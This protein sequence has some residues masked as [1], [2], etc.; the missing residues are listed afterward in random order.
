MRRLALI[1]LNLICLQSSLA[2][3]FVIK[4]DSPELPKI[5]AFEF[6]I[7][8]DP[9]GSFTIDDSIEVV[10]KNNNKVPVLFKFADVDN[11][12]IRVFLSD[13][14]NG[15]TLSVLGQFKR[16]NYRGEVSLAVAS[17]N[18]IPN[19]GQEVDKTN[20]K[21]RIEINKDNNILP[22]MGISKATLLGPTERIFADKLFI[23]IGK[24]ETYGFKLGRR[25][26]KAKINGQDAEI[27]DNVIIGSNL[28]LNPE[29]N[30]NELDV[31]LE[32]EVDNQT[33]SKKVGTIKLI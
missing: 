11:S 3:D 10:D 8:F 28:K 14:F 27:Y 25:I 31:I 7:S 9:K 1:L 2:E 21:S 29:T 15:N 16:V 23:S 30:H 22:Y 33:I 20:I 17:V 5:A 26:V 12:L 24:I 4:I 32:L 19:F 13:G 18:I 6:N